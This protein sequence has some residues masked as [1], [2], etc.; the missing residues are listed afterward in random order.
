L[1]ISFARFGLRNPR[2][3]ELLTLNRG[4]DAV[5]PPSGEEARRLLESP[6]EGLARGSGMSDAQLETLRLGLWSLLHGYILLRTAR[7]DEAWSDDVFEC[8]LDAL[9]DSALGPREAPR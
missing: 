2:H 3:Y 5:E 9:L 4:P 8:S 7:P 6:L 1:S